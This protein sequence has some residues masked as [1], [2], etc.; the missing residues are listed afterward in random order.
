VAKYGGTQEYI[1]N[2]FFKSALK[3]ALQGHSL[4]VTL[5]QDNWQS[6]AFQFYVGDL[7]EVISSTKNVSSFKELNGRCQAINDKTFSIEKKTISSYA[8]KVNFTCYL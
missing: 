5:S 6:R 1:S 4:D 8:V 7:H 3:Y 2:T